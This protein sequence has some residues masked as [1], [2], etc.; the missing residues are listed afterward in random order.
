MITG[1]MKSTNL[2]PKLITNENPSDMVDAIWV[3]VF[4]PSK[5]EESILE[6]MLNIEIPTRE[7]MR[8][9]E[10]SN[11][12]YMEKDAIYLTANILSK[13]DTPEPK[14]DAITLIITKEKLITIRYMEATIFSLF[15][16]HLAKLTPEDYHPL[17]LTVE[18]LGVSIDRLA[19]VLERIAFS[20]DKFSQGIFHSRLS[21]DSGT[22]NI[23]YKSILQEIG[24]NGDLSMKVGE[25]LMTINLANT[26]FWGVAMPSLAPHLQAKL[27]SL[28]KD[29]KA[30]STHV[31]L[32]SNKVTFLLD[33]TLGMVTIEQND[34]IK[35]FSIA[36]VMFLPPTLIASIYGMNFKFIPE[37]SWHYGYFL[38][39]GIMLLSAWLP[40]KF[41]K[42]KKWL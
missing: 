9:I 10:V 26:Y 22:P 5:E 1:Y 41:L 21:E 8:E 28:E 17:N 13:S 12:L 15:I 32:L 38:A 25:S 16:C 36:A 14:I 7:E 27:A 6:K 34:I 24:S 18:L 2:K 42:K 35:I 11:R 4:A 39:I 19:D 40:Y 29:I 3:D 31:N 20:L 33:A 30:L 23:D 37:L